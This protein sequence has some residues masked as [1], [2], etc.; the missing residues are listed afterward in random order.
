[1]PQKPFITADTASPFAVGRGFASP[2]EVPGMLRAAAPRAK[3]FPALTAV[4]SHRLT[5]N[6]KAEDTP[7]QAHGL[8]RISDLN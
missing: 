1:L 6:G 2:Y 8:I 3:S 4:H 7:E 5:A